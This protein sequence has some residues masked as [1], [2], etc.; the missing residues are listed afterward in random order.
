M[1]ARILVVDD[2]LPNVKVLEAKL[3]SEYYDVLTAF[4]GLDAIEKARTDKPDLI[5]LDVMMPGLDGFEVCRRL[6][7]DTAT[8]HI[9]VVMVTA[10]SDVRDRVT[11]IEAGADDFLTK[12]VDD[13]ALFAR[14]RSLIRLKLLMDELRLRQETSN[15]F[16]VSAPVEIDFTSEPTDARILAVED[17]PYEA[18]LIAKTLGQKHQVTVQADPKEALILARGGDFDLVVVSL[19]LENYDGLR[20]CSQLRSMEETRQVPILTLVDDGD[21]K[22]LVKGLEIGVNDYLLRAIDR[23]ELL[24]RSR[25]QIRRKRFQDKLRASFYRS[26]AQAVTDDLTG[27]HNRRYL[28]S[29][30]ETLLGNEQGGGMRS[31]AVMLLDIDHFKSINDTFGHDAGDQVLKEFAQRI[32]RNVRGVDLAARFGGEEFVV[33]MPETDLQ[34]A[35]VVAERLRQAFSDAPFVVKGVD[36]PIPV[37]CSI[38]VAV[39]EGR[40]PPEQIFK[41]ADEALYAAKRDGRNRVVA[42]AA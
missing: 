6:K 41:R 14:V 13:V 42:A 12:P 23:N 30:I 15:T 36:R 9:P 32:A 39:A 33:V 10:L 2:M 5:L 3:S 27:L 4:N 34:S 24:A 16:G 1:T 26:M 17:A 25:T 29:H 31:F 38:G 18:E 7:A 11:G 20:L 40:E 8:A 35:H 21:K 28:M 22:R 19:G 37:T